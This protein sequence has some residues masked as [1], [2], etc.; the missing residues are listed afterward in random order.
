[1]TVVVAV[2]GTEFFEADTTVGADRLVFG[3]RFE[4]RLSNSHG[5][6]VLTRAGLELEGRTRTVRRNAGL[7]MN[8]V[9]VLAIVF[10]R[11]VCH[12]YAAVTEKPE[13][14]GFPYARVLPSACQ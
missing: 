2:A 11:P 4:Y 7:D 9:G 14:E 12:L 13:T 1:M 5:E 8:R 10:V 6:Y 3:G